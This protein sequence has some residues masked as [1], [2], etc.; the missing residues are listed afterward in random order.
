M[1]TR[2]ELTKIREIPVHKLADVI[3]TTREEITKTVHEIGLGKQKNTKKVR[4][5]RKTLARTWTILRE[6]SNVTA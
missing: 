1:K 5:L 4:A 2:D 3:L 6:K